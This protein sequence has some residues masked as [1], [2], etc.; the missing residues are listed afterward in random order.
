MS[1][2]VLNPVPNPAI[3]IITRECEKSYSSHDRCPGTIHSGGRTY[4]CDCRCH[5]VLPLFDGATQ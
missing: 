5:K 4:V 3:H 1:A 2:T